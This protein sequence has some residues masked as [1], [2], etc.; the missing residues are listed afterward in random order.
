MAK[1]K[2][3]VKVKAKAKVNCQSCKCFNV[4]R[5]DVKRRASLQGGLARLPRGVGKCK[6]FH[7]DVLLANKLENEKNRVPH[8]GRLK[9]LD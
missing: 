9:S 4:K 2:V 5:K 3:K 1:V 8:V 7:V 6:S